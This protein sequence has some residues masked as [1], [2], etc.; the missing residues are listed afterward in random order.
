MLN[1]LQI[2]KILSIS[3]TEKTFGVSEMQG[4]GTGNLT[5]NIY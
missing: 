4:S 2:G 5:I 3:K 1:L